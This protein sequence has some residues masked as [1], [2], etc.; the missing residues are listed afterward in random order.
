MWWL[1]GLLGVCLLAVS[2]IAVVSAVGHTSGDT[3]KQRAAE[4]VS[5]A[6]TAVTHLVSVDAA[7]PDDYVD[8]VL[9][10][11]T[12]A[13]KSEFLERRDSV[14]EVLGGATSTT[15][16]RV[17]DAG[18]EHWAPDNSGSVLVVVQTGP[19]DGATAPDTSEGASRSLRIRV[20]VT[21]VDGEQKLSKVEFVS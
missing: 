12:G 19:K 1:C 14:V 10:D 6:R 3:A 21:S 7:Q 5:T 17:V 16:A 8:Q 4:A 18:F 20:A 13:W 2:T 15:V 11:A 9:D